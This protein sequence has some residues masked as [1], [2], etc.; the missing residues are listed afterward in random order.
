MINKKKA[1]KKER[2]LKGIAD[3]TVSAE[4]SQ[5]LSSIDFARKYMWAISNAHLDA[6]KKLRLTGIKKY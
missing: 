3:T 6:A 5:T 1:K 2:L 4:M